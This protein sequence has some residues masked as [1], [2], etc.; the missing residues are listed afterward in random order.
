M[1]NDEANDFLDEILDIKIIPSYLFVKKAVSS[2]I[3]NLYYD[4]EVYQLNNYHIYDGKVRT[5]FNSIN[6][7][8][9]DLVIKYTG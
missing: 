7:N 2:Y 6:D 9:Y 4:D 5:Y 1:K 8:L 3:V